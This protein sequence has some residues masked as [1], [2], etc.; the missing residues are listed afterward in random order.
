GTCWVGTNGGGVN[1]HTPMAERFTHV[2]VQP[3]EPNSIAANSVMSFC[4]DSS[5]ALWVGTDNGLH[6]W[7]PR[8]QKWQRFQHDPRNPRSMNA[9]E[10]MA[11]YADRSGTIWVG[12]QD[13]GLG[14][15]IRKEMAPNKT[16][17]IAVEFE[18]FVND[19]KNPK[20][21]S[22]N[23]VFT[24]YEDRDSVLW[25]GTFGGGLNRF[26]RKAKT[27][28]SYKH[29][30]KDS[31]SISGNAIEAIVE[32]SR[33]TLW[34]GTYDGG[35][36]CFDRRTQKFQR[37]QYD[38]RDP[39]S[40]SSNHVTCFHEDRAGN[41][42]IGTANGLNKLDA[43]RRHF[44]KYFEKD[45]LANSYLYGILEDDDANLWLS[46]NKGLSRFNPATGEF[47]NFGV[48]DGL[49]GN[50]F[51]GGAYYKS[52][53]GEM[54]FGGLNGFNRFFSQSIIDNPHV[55]PIALIDF[56]VFNRMVPINVMGVGTATRL[57]RLTK[58]ISATEEISLSYQHSVFSFEF[59]AL[60]YW[61]PEKNQYS[62][63][64]E[65]F[66]AEW[67]AAGT[68]NSA[69]Y[70]NLNPGE[71]VFRLRGANCDGVWNEEGASVKLTIAPPF[72]LTWW[73]RG[74]GLAA[75]AGL[76]ALLHHYRVQRLLELDRLR[77]R[78][79]SDLHDDLG[80]T[81]NAIA[82]KTEMMQAG[83][84]PEENSQQLTQ[85]GRMCRE[86]I[87]ALRDVVWSIDARN[88]RVKDLLDHMREF[89]EA[90]LAERN[91]EIQFVTSAINMEKRLAFNFRQNLYL[92]FKEALNNVLKYA[93]ASQVRVEMS[94]GEKIFQMKISDNGKGLEG[95]PQ[96]NGDGLRNMK[97]RAEQIGAEL[98]YENSAGFAVLLKRPAL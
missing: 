13:G 29:D 94:N 38:R 48:H 30:V 82:I 8:A 50:E 76:L 14:K 83:M 93:E 62:Y 59:A 33:G 75:A 4:E 17:E 43:G 25:I 22:N 52:R 20:S 87:K 92:I 36:S 80:S 77:V 91:I 3:H 49:Q 34:V 71:Y 11:V 67:I 5:G 12:L 45:G 65:G 81:L 39:R 15:L 63:K 37:Y 90:T 47:K 54:F 73:F 74:L 98:E 2:L 61:A 55:P 69:T 1:K 44:T 27:F 23:T 19:P 89:A 6:R 96:R 42:W 56:Q 97:L 21:L 64:M 78:L 84:A 53:N 51:N 26:D 24:I 58:S 85:I 95:A 88:D 31:N 28:F 9:G 18:R 32:D 46:T 79:A 86:M 41:L 35:L 68:K 70:T 66:D 16:G 10:A 7:N 60:D 57:P 40:L 72:W